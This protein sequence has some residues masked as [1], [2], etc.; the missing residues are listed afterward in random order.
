MP[1]SA[2][3]ERRRV[4]VGL[5][6]DGLGEDAAPVGRGQPRRYSGREA[7]GLRYSADY[8]AAEP[9]FDLAPDAPGQVRPVQSGTT[10]RRRLS[11]LH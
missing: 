2:P 7:G 6:P 9:A 8:F 4:G 10:V 11:L 3:V 1:I 5:G